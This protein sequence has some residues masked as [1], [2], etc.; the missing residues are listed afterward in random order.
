LRLSGDT[1]NTVYGN[2]TVFSGNGSQP[3]S[4]HVQTPGR[5][6][7]E[8]LELCPLKMVVVKTVYVA[9]GRSSKLAVLL[10]F[11]NLYSGDTSWLTIIDGLIGAHERVF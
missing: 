8:P 1:V 7:A 3:G 4:I 9:L 6:E 10:L 11:V 2:G 5:K